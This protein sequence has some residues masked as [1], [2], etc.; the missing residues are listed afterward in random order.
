MWHWEYS[1]IQEAM[2]GSIVEGD[3]IDQVTRFMAIHGA[4]LFREPFGSCL[5]ACT[6][7]AQPYIDSR[8][9]TFSVENARVLTPVVGV[10]GLRR[11]LAVLRRFTLRSPRYRNSY[12]LTFNP[13]YDG[14]CDGDIVLVGDEFHDEVGLFILCLG[15]DVA[16]WVVMSVLVLAGCCGT[17]WYCMLWMRSNFSW[18]VRF[19]CQ[20]NG[21]RA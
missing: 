11:R 15:D 3:D 19:R 16:G 21:V 5:G 2:Y 13:N 8:V 20:A 12:T 18:L 4:S 14:L 7:H 17:S 10:A 1:G 6:F 9:D